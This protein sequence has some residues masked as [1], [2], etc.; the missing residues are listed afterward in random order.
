MIDSHPMCICN[1]YAEPGP[2]ERAPNC[3]ACNPSTPAD[4]RDVR[5][6]QCATD[7]IA[8]LIAD[9]EYH[10]AVGDDAKI[11]RLIAAALTPKPDAPPTSKDFLGV[12]PPN[13]AR[14]REVAER[15]RI[16]IQHHW[17]EWQDSN[18]YPDP[19][20]AFLL[21]ALR[22]VRDRCKPDAP[23]NPAAEPEPI[24]Y[25]RAVEHLSGR[26]ETLEGALRRADDRLAAI[27]RAHQDGV[28]PS[29]NR[30]VDSLPTLIEEGE[31]ALREEAQ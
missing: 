1:P 5:I 31:K 16:E 23:P 4:P 14:L 8:W 9:T 13:D 19:M 12:A 2:V 18:A 25:H 24:N 26:I 17:Q 7:I 3:R 22:E 10:Y 29:V 27:H 28:H 21:A 15:L 11:V 6:A 30:L 20:E